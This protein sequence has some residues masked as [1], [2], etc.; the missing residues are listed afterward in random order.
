M[1]KSH[2]LSLGPGS[3]VTAASRAPDGGAG[4]AGAACVPQP[5][6][7]TRRSDLT[8]IMLACFA[9]SLW[10]AALLGL[11]QGLTEFIPVSSSAHLRIVPSLLGKP[12]A[13]VLFFVFF[14]FGLFFLVFSYNRKDL[15]NL[16]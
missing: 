12:D 11:V 10:L 4:C 3:S 13:G 8:P 16:A 7:T 6:N 1:S 15:V 2:S 9:M 5:S 14:L